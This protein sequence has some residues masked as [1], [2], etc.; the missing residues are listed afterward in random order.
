MTQR[1][2]VQPVPQAPKLTHWLFL[3]S[4]PLVHTGQHCPLGH[5]QEPF[6]HTL[7]LLQLTPAHGSGGC[8]VGGC[9]VGGW[10]FGS[11]SSPLFRLASSRLSSTHS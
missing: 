6:L 4:W 3:H 11:S 2:P 7:P 9:G 8:G 5:T 1:L 10:T